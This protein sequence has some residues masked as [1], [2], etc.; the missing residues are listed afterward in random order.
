MKKKSIFIIM[1]LC[2]MLVLSACGGSEV[3]ITSTEGEEISVPK[4][5]KFEAGKFS[6]DVSELTVAL[7]EGET[8]Q[9]QFFTNLESADFTGSADIEALCAWAAENPH[10]DVLYTVTLPDGTVLDTKSRSADL[11]AYSGEDVRL[12]ADSLRLLPGLKSI[13]L[14]AERAG[15]TWEDIDVLQQ[16]C[17]GVKIKYVFDL[18]GKDIDLQNTQLNLRNVGVYDWYEGCTQLRQALDHMP[19]LTY[20]DLDNAGVPSSEMEKLME[21]Y[22]HVDF[23]WRIWFGSDFNYSV[24]TDVEM[25]LASKPS[26]GGYISA[27]NSADLKYCTKVKYLDLGHNGTLTDISFVEHMPELE[28]AIIAMTGISDLSPFM[29]CPEL[30]YLE[31]QTTKITDLSPLAGLTKLRHINAAAIPALSDITP[32]YNITELERLWIGGYSAVPREQFEEMQKRAPGC[33]ICAEGLQDPTTGGWRT[34]MHPEGY[35][36]ADPRYIL[37]RMQFND[38]TNKSYSF[39]WNDPLYENYTMK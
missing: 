38:Y 34:S 23:V 3:T 10:V 24:R 39:Y 33:K 19:Q 13:E 11:S 7:A 31:M 4:N 18:Y 5:V 27:E 36:I 30:E 26:T 1:L 6:T 15:L 14:G 32:L 8:E 21:E 16:A 12:A 20:A 28:V 17:P 25:I 35:M 22:P 2:M 29:S 37:L 9:L